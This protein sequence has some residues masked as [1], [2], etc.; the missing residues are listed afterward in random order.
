MININSYKLTPAITATWGD[1][2]GNVS[3]QEDLVEYINEHGGNAAWGSI[4]GNISDQSDL[5]STLGSYATESWV[6]S[7]QFATESWVSEQGYLTSVPSEYATQSWV[8]EQGYLTST[9]L[10]GYATESW[11][12]EQGYLTEHQPLKKIWV[13]N[14]N[15]NVYMINWMN[16]EDEERPYIYKWNS[17]SWKFELFTY[18]GEPVH[19]T[20]NI[21]VITAVTDPHVIWCDTQNRYYFNNTHTITF[22]DTEWVFTEKAM[23]GKLQ[24]YNGLMSNI[25]KDA[26]TGLEGVWMYYAQTASSGTAYKFNEETQVFESQGAFYLPRSTQF[27]RYGF[28]YN[29]RYW[30]TYSSGTGI[31]LYTIMKGSG[32]QAARSQQAAWG[33]ASYVTTPEDVPVNVTGDRIRTV[34]VNNETKYIFYYNGYAWELD[35]SYEGSPKPWVYLDFTVY[36]SFAYNANGAECG[37]LMFGF[38][39]DANRSGEIPVW[40]FSKV[41]DTY[42]WDNSLEERVSALEQDYAGSVELTNNILGV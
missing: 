35:T 29:G 22:T 18:N 21:P 37:D 34:I 20:G 5:M 8:S 12:S 28:Y 19:I 4:S 32:T 2:T 27:F 6:S 16:L 30:Y 38:G 9:S 10:T 41:V 42:G 40:N 23:G 25:I 7:Q 11:V 36:D 1:I 14:I 33:I 17:D 26:S 24:T 31:I 15:N 39:Y 3:N 13:Y